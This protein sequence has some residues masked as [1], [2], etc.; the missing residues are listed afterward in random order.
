VRGLKLRTGER[1]KY[2][3]LPIDPWRSFNKLRVCILKCL[4]QDYGCEEV[5]P[6][7]FASLMDLYE[8]NF[9]RIRKLIPCLSEMHGQ[10]SCVARVPKKAYSVSRVAGCLDLHCHILEQSKYTTTFV[11]T[12]YFAETASSD[13]FIG[14]P[15]LR[16][17]AYHDAGL[18]EVLTGHLLHGRQRYDQMP[19]K[20]VQVKWRLNRLLYKWLGFSLHLGHHFTEFETKPAKFV[21]SAAPQVIT[22]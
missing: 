17:R 9:I 18:V 11:L 3:Q 7:G 13:S 2:Q 15:Q 21:L 20:A 22:L 12:Y 4:Q 10:V 14:E 6:R 1:I 5:V 19:T 8:N 16:C